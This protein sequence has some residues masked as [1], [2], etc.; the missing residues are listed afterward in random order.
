MEKASS[1]L[2][3]LYNGKII[4]WE[5]RNPPNKKKRQLLQKLEAEEQYFIS[6]LSQDDCARFQELSNL[7]LQLSGV[8][9]ENLWAYS[10]SL[11]MLLMMDVMKESEALINS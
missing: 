9:E 5:R 4:P 1:I 11:G 6:K 3:G 10:F 8:D 2:E 7:H